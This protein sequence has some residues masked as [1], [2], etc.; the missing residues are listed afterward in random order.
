MMSVC[1]TM[2]SH[3]LVHRLNNCCVKN[4]KFH[5]VMVTFI[6]NNFLNIQI[7]NETISK[8]WLFKSFKYKYHKSHSKYET[9]I[10][11]L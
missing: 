6:R 11:E 1:Q 10:I 8:W 9:N 3:K 7:F 5:L 2:F 4:I